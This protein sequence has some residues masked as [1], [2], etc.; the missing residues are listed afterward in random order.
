M[1]FIDDSLSIEL[2]P[3]IL[4]D[5]VACSPIQRLCMWRYPD[6]FV[7]GAS[8][9]H[10]KDYDALSRQRSLS[11]S[12]DA[13]LL[14]CNGS[15]LP[16]TVGDD[17]ATLCTVKFHGNGKES[18]NKSMKPSDT[19]DPFLLAKDISHLMCQGKLDIKEGEDVIKISN[20]HFLNVL[21][22]TVPPTKSIAHTVDSSKRKLFQNKIVVVTGAK[23]LGKTYLS[24][25]IAANLRLN[26]SYMT[27]YFDCQQLQSSSLK[28]EEML[29]EVTEVCKEA[30]KLN[31]S[32]LILDNLDALVPNIDYDTSGIG[33]KQR[34]NPNFANQVKVL[35]D[36]IAFL[37]KGV[38]R[39]KV[40]LLVTCKSIETIHKTFQVLD[41][42]EIKVPTLTS[43]ERICLFQE[44]IR[45]KLDYDDIILP[46]N[47]SVA[48]QFEY[49]NPSDL[50]MVTAQI[51]SSF[52]INFDEKSIDITKLVEDILTKYIPLFSQSMN[53]CHEDP[54]V[55]WCEI[56]GLFEAKS[57]LSAA[58]LQPIAYKQ[59][60]ENIPIRIPK[61]IFLFGPSGCG[62]SCLV[63]ALAAE[64]NFNLITCRGPELYDKYIG[65]SEAKVR[66]IFEKAYAASPSILFLDEFDSLA[67]RRGSDNTGVTDRVVN[68]LLTFLDGVEVHD[69]K[70]VYIIAASSRPDKIDPALLR[71]GR[72][73]NHVYVG[74]A[75]DDDEWYNLF[76]NI[77]LKKDIS[78][79]L[80]DSLLDRSFFE[81][82]FR[83]KE[84]SSLP[85]HS[86]SAADIKG[87]FNTAHLN[88]IHKLLDSNEGKDI[89]AETTT[90]IQR[91]D[92]L[93]A[94]ESSRP[95]LPH[96]DRLQLSRA[97]LPFIGVDCDDQMCKRKLGLY[98]WDTFASSNNK[99]GMKTTLK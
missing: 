50:K 39:D 27:S 19:E 14:I 61:G 34:I 93:E 51:A 86:F 91:D 53:I 70:D 98:S 46:T 16:L 4:Y 75:K 10:S 28:L 52:S 59:I 60:Y 82:L 12:Q 62:K 77:A 41:L 11:L 55:K 44:M 68:Q 6:D 96:S 23:G 92:L 89:K 69:D 25:T 97:Y 5:N 31:P 66:Q 45:E 40:L 94:I 83:R 2:R 90:L 88:A 47:Y 32:L 99:G 57:N 3:F 36:H 8:T 15:I 85:Y 58:I 20:S 24:L 87:V 42:A 38:Q 54:E 9:A 84:K 1:S 37:V 22:S 95:S 43:I 56:G 17:D 48:E 64:C 80:K 49:Y 78:Q 26:H 13:N 71:P 35:S 30:T 81:A 74:F 72:L 18:N 67:P 7:H 79:E 76:T 33:Q 29:Q 65:A 21:P 73:E 63:P